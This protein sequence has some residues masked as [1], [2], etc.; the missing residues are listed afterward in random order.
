MVLENIFGVV[1][2]S[3]KRLKIKFKNI[4]KLNKNLSDED[5]EKKIR[6][7]KNKIYLHISI[8]DNE[9]KKSF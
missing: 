2:N 3:L 9:V 7:L 1:E 6:K 8:G 4:S 5:I